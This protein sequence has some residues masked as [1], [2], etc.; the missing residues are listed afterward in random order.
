MRVSELFEAAST[1][2]KVSDVK[3]TDMGDGKFKVAVAPTSGPLV[4]LIKNIIYALPSE[5]RGSITSKAGLKIGDMS[6]FKANGFIMA[7]SKAAVEKAVANGVKK[8]NDNEQE[9]NKRKE[10]APAR[11]AAMAKSGAAARKISASGDA[12]KY[13]K[14]TLDRIKFKQ[15]GG[16]DGY[17]Y[18]LFIDGRKTGYTGMTKSEAEFEKRQMAE[19]IAKKEKLGKWAE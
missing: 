15:V 11:K 8:F 5:E 7:A 14:G 9:K 19:K 10:E 2:V 16:D 18:A 12:E 13:G 3:V 6:S 1:E 4:L 17:C